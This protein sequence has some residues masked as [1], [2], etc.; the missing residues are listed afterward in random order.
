MPINFIK[1]E[2]TKHGFIRSLHVIFL[3]FNLSATHID[4]K[5]CLDWQFGRQICRSMQ[6]SSRHNNHRNNHHHKQCYSRFHHKYTDLSL[7]HHLLKRKFLL[8]CRIWMLKR[9]CRSNW[10]LLDRLGVLDLP[11]IRDF[12]HSGKVECCWQGQQGFVSIGKLFGRG[13]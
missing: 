12:P 2:R 1:S 5:H 3:I 7:Y 4:C 8:G 13:Q 6:G 10:L 9:R 11:I